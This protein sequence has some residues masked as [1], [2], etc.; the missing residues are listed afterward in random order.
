[1]PVVKS[2][3][4]QLQHAERA[5]AAV[6]VSVTIDEGVA[7]RDFSLSTRS[8]PTIAALDSLDR[9]ASTGRADSSSEADS[10]HADLALSGVRC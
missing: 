1:M 9:L 7:V 6:R 10:A 5:S 3:E 8:A 4:L 2:L